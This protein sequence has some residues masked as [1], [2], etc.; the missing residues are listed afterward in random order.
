[1]LRGYFEHQR[2]VQFEGCAAEPLQ[3]ITATLPWVKVE[4]F[5][6][7]HCDALS[8]VTQIYP[9]PRLRVFV[10]DISAFMHGRN[11]ALAEMAQKV[12]IRLKREE[13]EK[14]LKLS[15]IVGGKQGKSQAITSCKYL[16][17]RF[18]FSNAARKKELCWRRVWKRW[19][20]I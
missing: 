12:L 8:E 16:E 13:E 17:E 2:R 1:M 19:A 18:R 4:L 15:I 10:D 9:P 5:A 20:W 11:K 6:P 7:G 14:G 3:T